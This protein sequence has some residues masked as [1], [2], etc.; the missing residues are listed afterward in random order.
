[1]NVAILSILLIFGIPVVA[2]LGWV[3]LEAL[4]ILRGNGGK[5]T[6]AMRTDETRLIQEIHRGLQ[7]MA[8][9]VEALETIL[10]D[11]IG[12]DERK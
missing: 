7:D 6:P 5:E 3:F 2:I 4:K 10:F 11:Q 1:M 9:R 8:R 12:K